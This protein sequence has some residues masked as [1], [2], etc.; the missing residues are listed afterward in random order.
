MQQAHWFFLSTCIAH[1]HCAPSLLRPSGTKVGRN[2]LTVA[3][4][5]G[6]IWAFMMQLVRR[7]SLDQVEA[8]MAPPESLA[9]AVARVQRQVSSGD[10]SG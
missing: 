9:A 3:A 5:D 10:G 4:A 6:G 1:R 7:R 8:L 2:V